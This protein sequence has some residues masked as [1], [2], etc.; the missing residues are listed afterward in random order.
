MRANLPEKHHHLSRPLGLLAELHMD[1]GDFA[2]AE[3][4][5]LEIKEIA[6]G[7]VDP[8]SVEQ[9]NIDIL[10]ARCLTGLGR[11]PEAEPPLMHAYAVFD[12]TQGTEN[13]RTQRAMAG[14][15]KLYTAWE[16]PD[17]AAAWQARITHPDFQ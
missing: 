9:C 8:E 12:S 17:E 3:P 15:V 6:A 7:A 5:M 14:L 13:D 10:W 1:R 2:G 11:Y 4:L 16:K